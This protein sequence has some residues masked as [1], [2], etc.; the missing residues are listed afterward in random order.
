MPAGTGWRKGKACPR[1]ITRFVEPC[2]LL[3]LH[4]DQAHGYDLLEGLKE[5]SVNRM[6]VDSSVVYRTLRNMEEAGMVISSWETDGGGPPRRV[7]NVTAVGD[8]Y[9]AHWVNELRETDRVLHAFLAAY[10]TLVLG[11]GV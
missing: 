5:F 7:Y 3:L 9:L 4:R 1:R 11:S 2:L 10:D 8:E 6:P